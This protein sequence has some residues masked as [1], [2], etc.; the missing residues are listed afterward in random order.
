MASWRTFL[1]ARFFLG[2]AMVFAHAGKCVAACY[3]AVA[4]GY[5]TACNWREDR[6]GKGRWL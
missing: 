1:F 5:V 6:G 2:A 4:G 3:L